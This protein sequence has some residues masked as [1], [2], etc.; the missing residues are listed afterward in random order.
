MK[1]NV[2]IGIAAAILFVGGMAYRSHVNARVVPTVIG[3]AVSA[4]GDIADTTTGAVTG[5][6]GGRRAQ[7]NNHDDRDDDRNGRSRRSHKNR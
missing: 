1:R 4:V 6:F 3:G 5:I 2:K 7:K